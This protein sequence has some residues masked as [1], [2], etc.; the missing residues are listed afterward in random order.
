MATSTVL[1]V[2]PQARNG[3]PRKKWPV[4]EPELRAALGP[5]T[6]RFTKHAGEGRPLAKADAA[7]RAQL[8][9]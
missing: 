7:P 3:W 5:L 4:I 2:N 1:I 8:L 9:V 6:L